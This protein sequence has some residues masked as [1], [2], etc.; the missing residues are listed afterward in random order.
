MGGLLFSVLFHLPVAK[1]AHAIWRVILISLELT[2]DEGVVRN[3]SCSTKIRKKEISHIK[4]RARELLA[5][6]ALRAANTLKALL[7]IQALKAHTKSRS[8]NGISI[9]GF[10]KRIS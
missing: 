5:V 3:Y 7:A 8:E 6:C 1:V 4:V 2:A 10:H 9:T